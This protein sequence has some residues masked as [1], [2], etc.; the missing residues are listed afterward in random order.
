M[1]RE[2]TVGYCRAVDERAG[3]TAW[4]GGVG[5]SSCR[6]CT[7]KACTYCKTPPWIYSGP[8]REIRCEKIK[9][10]FAGSHCFCKTWKKEHKITR[11]PYHPVSWQTQT[12]SF[13]R[14]RVIGMI[15]F[16]YFSQLQSVY[17]ANLRNQPFLLTPRRLRDVS[18]GDW[19]VVLLLGKR[20]KRRGE[21]WETAVFTGCICPKEPIKNLTS[22]S[23]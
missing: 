21:G 8:F 2:F 14:E 13:L 15:F 5:S 10:R 1:H 11:I 12:R 16:P 17:Y 18:Q 9:D 3:V 22:M 6:T 23:S 19:D 20:P 4:T 7:Q